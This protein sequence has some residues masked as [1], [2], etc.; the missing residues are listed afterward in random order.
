LGFV[1]ILFATFEVGRVF[2]KMFFGIIGI[3]ISVAFI[4]L[5]VCLSLFGPAPNVPPHD[6]EEGNGAVDSGGAEEPAT[7]S[8]EK[9]GQGKQAAAADA[10]TTVENP[11]ADTDGNATN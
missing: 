2:A 1:P 8:F 10:G 5:P 4:L 6:Y 11:V 7:G 3:G 9:E